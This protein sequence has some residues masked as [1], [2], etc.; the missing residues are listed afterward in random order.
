MHKRK[1]DQISFKGT[2]IR[3]TTDF[4][5]EIPQVRKEWRLIVQVLQ[6][7]RKTVNSEYCTQKK[8]HL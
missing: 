3:F 8:S 2:L 5:A 7:K 4:S 1:T 6:E